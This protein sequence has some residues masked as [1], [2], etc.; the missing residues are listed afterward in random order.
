MYIRVQPPP[1]RLFFVYLCI[2]LYIF[3]TGPRRLL[4]RRRP[5]ARPV[6][7]FVYLCTSLYIFVFH[8][9][10]WYSVSEEAQREL[11]RGR[12]VSCSG[13]LLYARA[14]SDASPDSTFALSFFS[15]QKRAHHTETG[16]LARACE[17]HSQE[18]S[19]SE[20]LRM[21]L[22][23]RARDGDDVPWRHATFRPPDDS[24]LGV[25]HTLR[26][27]QGG[28]LDRSCPLELGVYENVFG[29]LNCA[30]GRAHA[31]RARA[32]R[33]RCSPARTTQSRTKDQCT[34]VI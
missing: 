30:R 28:L 17:L 22:R 6:Y 32:T 24:G 1:S 16:H 12:D 8:C 10:T 3:V 25:C 23:G 31:R 2:S 34:W 13:T 27:F 33:P 18:Q 7:L 26:A 19:K 4:R 14:E 11:A 21:M 15:S 20:V 5:A 9:A 29:N